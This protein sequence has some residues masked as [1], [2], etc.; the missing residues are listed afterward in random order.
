M[1][2]AFPSTDLHAV[3]H[4]TSK[5]TTWQNRYSS[6]V[7]AKM[8]VTCV[9]INTTTNKLECTD[10]HWEAIVKVQISRVFH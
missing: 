7:S 4:I 3:P 10:D 1:R 9:G 2:K 6:I 5:I 8:I